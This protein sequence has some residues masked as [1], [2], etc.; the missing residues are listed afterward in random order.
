MYLKP[1]FLPKIR[2]RWSEFAKTAPNLINRLLAVDP[3]VKR[4]GLH[5]DSAPSD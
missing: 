3:R 4:I 2:R 5:L 1:K